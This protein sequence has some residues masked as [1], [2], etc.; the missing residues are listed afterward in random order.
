M[1]VAIIQARMSSSRLPQ[2]V[3]KN[4]INKPLL[5]H[6]TER[7]LSSKRVDKVIIATSIQA[8]DD[9]IYELCKELKIDCYR[10]SLQDVLDR[11][12][13]AAS[14]FSADHIVRLTGDCP[15]IDANLIDSVIDFHLDSSVEYTSNCSPPT[16]P[17]GYDVEVFTF[18][19]LQQAWQQAEK[20]S[21][22]EHVTPYIRNMTKLF[23]QN[24]FKADIDYSR[25]RL[26][27]DEPEDLLLITRIFEHFYADKANF[28]LADVINFL[29]QQ[30]EIK[31]INS[32]F[33][34]NEGLIKSEL[35]DKELGYD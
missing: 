4:V 33:K 30:P 19:A 6:Q 25:Y 26:T 10:G 5:K 21:E 20:P 34:R 16:F 28:E 2:K 3:L 17:D 31:K 24:N 1:I 18:N 32:S 29:E 11:F 27:V 9:P 7:V 35:E 23:S 22:R 12:Y 8:E 14:Q 13:Q 15:L